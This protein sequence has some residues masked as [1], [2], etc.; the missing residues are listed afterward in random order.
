[1]TT[2][3]FAGTCPP[4]PS[5]PLLRTRSLGFLTSTPC[6]SCIFSV[7]FRTKMCLIDAVDLTSR[8]I[9]DNSNLKTLPYNLF[10]DVRVHALDAGDEDTSSTRLPC[11]PPT[12]RSLLHC[13]SSVILPETSSLPTCAIV[14]FSFFVRPHIF[15]CCNCTRSK[16]LKHGHCCYL[17]ASCGECNFFPD[18]LGALYRDGSSCTSACTVL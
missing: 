17:Q 4:I 8:L 5:M 6:E 10:A 3:L 2:P 1:M 12:Y 15:L 7:A 18:Y 9:K 16:Y 11:K 14:S 13:L